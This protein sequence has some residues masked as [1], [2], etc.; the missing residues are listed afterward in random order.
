MT[1]EEEL[2]QY[3]I[4]L[5]EVPDNVWDSYVVSQDLYARHY[6]QRIREVIALRGKE[7]GRNRAAEILMKGQTTD[8]LIYQDKLTLKLASPDEFLM[9]DSV[10]FAEYH[11]GEIKISRRLLQALERHKDLLCRHLGCFCPQDILF[12]HELFHH[13]EDTVEGLENAGLIVEIK[14]VP[15]FTKKV[16]PDSAGE[17]AAYEFSR[18][19]SGIAFHPYVLGLFG[20]YLFKKSYACKI[21]KDIEYFIE[22]TI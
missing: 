16:S 5:K 3:L 11:N 7:T 9:P 12:Y 14:V 21:V 15:F 4:Y 1:P 13:Y 20:L 17:I 10:N 8:E 2:E 22:N 19:V 6:T 18:K